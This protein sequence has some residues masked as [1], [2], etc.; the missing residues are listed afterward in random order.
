VEGFTQAKEDRFQLRTVGGSSLRVQIVLILKF[1]IFIE[2]L[3][4]RGN[5]SLAFLNALTDV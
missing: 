5:K 1:L 3:I 4:F 2:A